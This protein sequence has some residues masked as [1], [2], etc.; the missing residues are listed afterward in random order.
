[1]KACRQMDVY[2][3]FHVDQVA[4]H[5]PNPS[6]AVESQYEVLSLYLPQGKLILTP[7]VF[8]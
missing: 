8:P 2:L 6:V 5:L 3:Y 4:G 7:Y 1:M